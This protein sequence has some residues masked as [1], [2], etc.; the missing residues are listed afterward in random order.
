MT[1]NENGEGEEPSTNTINFFMRVKYMMLS[2]GCDIF[3]HTQ[4]KL[5]EEKGS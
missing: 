3:F 2:E 5:A 4:I 1:I